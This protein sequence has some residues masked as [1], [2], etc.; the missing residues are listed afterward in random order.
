[1][2]ESDIE[3]YLRC[4]TCGGYFPKREAVNNVFC[5][6]FCLRKYARCRVCGGFYTKDS[7]MEDDLCSV[8]CREKIEY[9]PG[10]KFLKQLKGAVS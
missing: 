10:E 8:E 6:N 4:R 7:S 3:D 1:M 5:S 9:S 2:E